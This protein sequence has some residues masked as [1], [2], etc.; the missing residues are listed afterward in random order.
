MTW[1]QHKWTPE[2][3]RQLAEILKAG[4]S[5]KICGIK[6]GGFEHTRDNGRN[7]CIGRARRL[8]LLGQP[9]KPARP[10]PPPKPRAP[11]K[12]PDLS[13]YYSA[14]AERAIAILAQIKL[15][16][17]P[18]A[19]QC[20]LADLPETGCHWPVTE[21]SPFLFC[22]AEQRPDSSY[23][24]HHFMRSIRQFEPE[25]STATRALNRAKAA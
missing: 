18:A 25:I 3:D 11:R 7:A 23:C 19:L 12:H 14:K 8:G 16:P 17:E 15:P 6:L 24:T 13:R 20:T 1:I 21:D 10:K 5:F 22:G 9:R 4:A 2:R